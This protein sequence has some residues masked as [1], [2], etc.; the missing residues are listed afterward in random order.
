V[1]RDECSMGAAVS[2]LIDDPKR[3]AVLGDAAQRSVRANWSLD[4]AVRRLEDELKRTV[5]VVT[6]RTE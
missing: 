5:Q 6:K 2:K 3:A 4:G 1:D